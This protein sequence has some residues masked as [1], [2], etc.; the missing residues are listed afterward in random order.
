MSK[1]HSTPKAKMLPQKSGRTH[2]DRASDELLAHLLTA[3][4]CTVISL[5]TDACL[6]RGLLSI[7]I[8]NS[9]EDFYFLAETVVAAQVAARQYGL[10][11]SVLLAIARLRSGFDPLDFATDHGYAV[12]FGSSAHDRMQ[13]IEQSFIEEARHLAKTRSLR[14]LMQVADDPSA[15]FKKLCEL[16]WCDPGELLDLP[17]LAQ[18]FKC[19]DGLDRVRNDI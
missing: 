2:F 12:S 6:K 10:R 8:V 17:R 19:A 9:L 15:Y 7:P 5:A 18:D 1:T 11:A 16:G 4:G 3:K 14:P 13:A